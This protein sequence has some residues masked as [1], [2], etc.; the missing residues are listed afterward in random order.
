VDVPS[1]EGPRRC[2]LVVRAGAVLCLDEA[3]T[4]VSGAAVAVDEGRIVAVGGADEVGR[5]WVADEVVDR[6]GHVLL[7]GFVNTHTHLGMT[8]LRGV[9]DDRDLDAFLATVVPIESRLLDA[10]RVALATR[11]AG[12]ESVLAGVTTALDMYFFAES[13]VPAAASVGLRV[14]SGP[15][16]FDGGPD[17]LPWEE[18]IAAAADWLASHPA[19]PGVRPVIGPH[20]TYLVSPEHLAAVQELAA[21]HAALVQVHA[22]ETAAEVELVRGRHGVGPIA[23]LHSLDLLGPHTVLAHAV[24]LDDDDLEAVVRTGAAVAHCPASNLKLASGVARIPELLGA[25]ATVGIGTDGPASSNDLDV[26]GATRLASLLHKGAPASGAPDAADLPAEAAL[27]AATL[28][29]AKAL[30]IEADL[31]SLEVGKLADLV[32]IDLDRP[33]VQPVHDVASAVLYAAGRG[34]VTDVW[35]AGRRVVADGVPTAPEAATV[36]DDLRDLQ[37]VVAALRDDGGRVS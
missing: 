28:G 34:D 21:A 29:G 3:G 7:P 18:Q 37:R 25:G 6:P 24:H 2:D 35:S 27:R 19:G 26:L 31:G 33:H 4:R 14:L 11:A 20:S 1:A 15:V 13:G 5:R 17:S 16:V 9:A 10:D 12:V 32:A 22:A 8:M 36:T 30:G 23:L